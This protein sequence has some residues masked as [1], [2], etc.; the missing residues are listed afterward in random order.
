MDCPPYTFL[1]T[2][3]LAYETGIFRVPCVNNTTKAITANIIPSRITSLRI[4]RTPSLIRVISVTITFGTRE[5]IPT[6]IIKEIP[7]PIPLSVIRSPIHIKSI[8]PV[9]RLTIPVKINP[10]PG[11][12]TTDCPPADIEG[13][14]TATIP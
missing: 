10:N 7:F 1:P 3:R 9:T 5:T 11:L 8:V 14:N 2:T 4:P 13:K 12:I 6:I